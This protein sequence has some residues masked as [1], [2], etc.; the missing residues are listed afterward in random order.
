MN[1][2]V[3]SFL[4]CLRTDPSVCE[5]FELKFD[6]AEVSVERCELA[7][8]Q[9][10]V[11]WVRQNPKYKVKGEIKCKSAEDSEIAI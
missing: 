10:L 11:G 6:A 1:L 4:A 5:T 8:Q 2:T 7:F 3:L 9:V